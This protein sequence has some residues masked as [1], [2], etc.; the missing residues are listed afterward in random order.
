MG[1]LASFILEIL[2]FAPFSLPYHLVEPEIAPSCGWS[3]VAPPYEGLAEGYL[4]AA[5]C[6]ERLPADRSDTPRRRSADNRT[7]AAQ[8]ALETLESLDGSYGRA[9]GR[10]RVL[11]SFRLEFDLA[12]AQYAGWS[13]ASPGGLGQAH[14]AFRFAQSERAQF[15][16]A[17]GLRHRLA[18]GSVSEGSTRSTPSTSSGRARWRRPSRCQAEASVPTGGP[19]KYGR[20]WGT[21]SARSRRTQG[22]TASGSGHRISRPNSW[23][24]RFLG[25]ARTSDPK[26]R[27]SP[28]MTGR[29]HDGTPRHSRT[30]GGTT[31][32]RSAAPAWRVLSSHP[33]GME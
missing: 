7:V 4:E 15:R 33:G 21:C 23:E 31:V 18:D 14:V 22:G 8:V 9:H 26:R 24:V 5:R 32:V 17:A 6:D 13:R 20:R 16:V 19:S 29:S 30:P 25:P 2:L 10:A 1:D 27:S 11:T 28:P 3:F 12:Y